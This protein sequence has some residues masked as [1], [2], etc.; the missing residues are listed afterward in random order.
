MLE[1]KCQMTKVLNLL[2]SQKNLSC[3]IFHKKIDKKRN[4]QKSLELTV[5]NTHTVTASS[6]RPSNEVLLKF[7]VGMG[8][9]HVKS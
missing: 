4:E 6:K 1:K 5:C 3:T 2:I 9:Y 8:T 7:S